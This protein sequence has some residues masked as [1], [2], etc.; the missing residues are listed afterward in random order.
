M[1]LVMAGV[2]G[3]GKGTQASLLSKQLGIPH[4]STGDIFRRAIKMGTEL[5]KLAESLITKGHFVPDEV[6]MGV[7]LERI[8]EPDCAKGYILDG[9]PRTLAQAKGAS[10]RLEPDAVVVLEVNQLEAVERI[11]QRLTCL[12]CGAVFSPKHHR[13]EIGDACCVCGQGELGKRDD[14][15]QPIALE[16]MD[17]YQRLTRPAVELM[18]DQW[19]ALVIDGS[20]TIDQVFADILQ[21]LPNN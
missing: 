12:R 17:V 10:R 11:V 4:I 20:G 16:R 3:S 13:V 2:P 5:G 18:K 21:G 7:V 19:P 14:D 15:T 1:Q 9:F 6:T 8:V